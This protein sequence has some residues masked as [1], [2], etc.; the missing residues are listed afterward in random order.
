MCTPV[1]L[2]HESVRFDAP[3]MI[4]LDLGVWSNACKWNP[5]GP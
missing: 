2:R 1:G 5:I 4:S 3:L